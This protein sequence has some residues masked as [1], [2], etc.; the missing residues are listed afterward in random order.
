M[1]HRET[2]P[3]QPADMPSVRFRPMRLEDVPDVM[4]I[5]HES[6]SLPWTEQAFRSEMTLNHFARYLI[7]EVDGAPAGY[8][9]MWTVVE[10]AHITNIAVRTAY[11]GR[12]LGERLLSELL[13]TA[14]ALGLERATL[15]VRVS[16]AV[17]RSL[18]D[19]M[20]FREVGIRKGYYSDNNEDAVIMWIDLEHRPLAA[21]DTEGS[22]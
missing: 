9:G 8:A 17:A 6:F 14:A 11:R 21:E 10:E 19:K 13:D 22:V 7:M 16:N 18:Y 15:E 4:V 2:G 1:Q 20:G 3:Q 12:K 5:E